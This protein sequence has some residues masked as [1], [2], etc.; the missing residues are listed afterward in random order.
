MSNRSKSRRRGT[1]EE[2]GDGKWL[3]RV[4]QG[5]DPVTGNPIRSS[6]L[7]RG[8]RKD[9]EQALTALLGQQDQGL[10]LPRTKETLHA[11][12]EEFS[13]VW[14]GDLAPQT[15]ENQERS[16]RCYL[17][18]PLRAK[19]LQNLVSRDFQELYNALSARGLAPTTVGFFHRVIRARLNKAVDL[20]RIVRNPTDGASPPRRVRSEYRVL[21][22]AEAGIFLEEVEHDDYGALWTLLLLTRLRPAEALALKWEDLEGDRLAVRRALVRLKAVEWRL[23]KTKTRKPRTVA[24][25]NTALRSLVRHR[26]RQAQAKLLLGAEYAPL[27]LIFASTLGQPL[28]W[29]N[30]AGRHFRPL[31]ERVALRLTRKAAETYQQRGMK[32]AERKANYAGIRGSGR[33][34]LQKTGLDRMRPYDLRHSAAT[35]LLAA[36]E[37]PKVV[38]ELLGHAKVTLTLDTYSHVLPGLLDSAARRME[39]IVSGKDL[40]AGFR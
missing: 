32:R 14:S 2:K 21:S 24:L 26:A 17:P 6:K 9:A 12:L 38:A 29:A 4:F 35:L 25:P 33:A 5:A 16:I 22:P 40:K 36:G 39:T 34:A 3:V 10:P 15:R 1:I 19:R 20:G 27:G 23:E 13:Q 30:L 8:P 11:W 37:H 7:V 31:L 18:A 28:H